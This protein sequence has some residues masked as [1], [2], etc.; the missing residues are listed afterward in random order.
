[1]TLIS[2]SRLFTTGTS[3]NRDTYNLRRQP[4]A[5][6][7]VVPSP[8]SPDPS[9]G[10]SSRPPARARRRPTPAVP[11]PGSPQAP[12]FPCP[13]CDRAFPTKIGLGL[14]RRRA[15]EAIVN[16]EVNVERINRQWSA[17][18]KRMMAREE[19]L[20]AN[21]GVRFI[22]QHLLT[23]VPNRTL[24]AIKG[25]RKNGGYQRLVAAALEDL[26]ATSSSESSFLS[27]SGSSLP[28]SPQ[29]PAISPHGSPGSPPPS[30]PSPGW[31]DA[32]GSFAGAIRALIPVVEAIQGWK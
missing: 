18:E 27:A 7:P 11:V 10:P 1:M 8:P 4:R 9:P 19:A 30:P 31:G 14:H 23:V 2:P 24:D 29:D 20:A 17:E 26:A 15:H 12:Q 32:Y 25:M 3:R 16:E 13:H 22:N 6:G 21:R 28:A 5:A